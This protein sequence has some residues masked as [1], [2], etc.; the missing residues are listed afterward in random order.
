MGERG[1]VDGPK[2][3]VWKRQMQIQ[4]MASRPSFQHQ[5]QPTCNNFA[6]RC[7]KRRFLVDETETE[8]AERN[9]AKIAP[10]L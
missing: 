2:A 8:V 3:L 4:N 1:I 5:K 6:D 9:D 7:W 10:N